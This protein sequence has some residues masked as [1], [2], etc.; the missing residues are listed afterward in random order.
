[1]ASIRSGAIGYSISWPFGIPN[2][3]NGRQS[4]GSSA[5]APLSGVSHSG[6]PQL[7]FEAGAVVVIS[8]RPRSLPSTSPSA[9]RSIPAVLPSWS[10]A[11][12]TARLPANRG[13]VARLPADSHA[14]GASGDRHGCA[15]RAG[16]C[17]SGLPPAHR[18]LAEGIPG[19]LP[20]PRTHVDM[21]NTQAPSQQRSRHQPV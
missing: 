17:S 10:C 18:H 14:L 21:I 13:D 6:R 1:M 15:G 8:G 5:P 20:P 2:S 4:D 16:I 9:V 3:A 12:L 19:R 11:P 7:L